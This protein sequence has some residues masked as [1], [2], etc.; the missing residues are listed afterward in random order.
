MFLAFNLVAIKGN[1]FF[2]N[3]EREKET[4]Q[5]QQCD[6]FTEHNVKCAVKK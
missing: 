3:Y 4:P 6:N 1:Y 2:S 5:T